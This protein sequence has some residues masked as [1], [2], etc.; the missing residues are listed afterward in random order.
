VFLG[1]TQDAP[2]VARVVIR[3]VISDQMFQAKVIVALVMAMVASQLQCAAACVSSFCDELAASQEQK[4]PPC[5]RHHGQTPNNAP[6]RCNHT[7]VNAALDLPAHAARVE[8]PLFFELTMV[9]PSP[10]ELAFLSRPVRNS[11]PPGLA[12][13]STITVLRI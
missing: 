7:S 6:V 1:S 4:L 11:S 2:A 3:V 13:P 5:H 12:R 10:I 9:Q 8:A